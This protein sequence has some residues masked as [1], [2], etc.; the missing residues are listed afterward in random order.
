[1]QAQAHGEA[2]VSYHT[3]MLFRCWCASHPVIFVLAIC[4]IVWSGSETALPIIGSLL[5]FSILA[6]QAF[7]VAYNRSLRRDLEARPTR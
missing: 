5:L 3:K 2:G 1:M 7:R 6:G 4:A